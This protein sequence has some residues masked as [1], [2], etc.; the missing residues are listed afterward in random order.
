MSNAVNPQGISSH[1]I[2][3]PAVDS[4]VASGEGAI[5]EMTKMVCDRIA[6]GTGG[7]HVTLSWVTVSFLICL[8]LFV[9]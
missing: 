5:G 8:D 6:I 1:T 3:L 9:F 7:I 2:S 4:V